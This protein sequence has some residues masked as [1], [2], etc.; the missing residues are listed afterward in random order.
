M[1]A[2]NPVTVS[3]EIP[4]LGMEQESIL[5]LIDF[6]SDPMPSDLGS[7][8]QNPIFVTETIEQARQQLQE[9][10]GAMGGSS[11]G[12]TDHTDHT[13]HTDHICSEQNEAFE[14]LKL[15]F[16]AKRNPTL[17]ERLQFQKAENE[18]L[19]R[20]NLVKRRK[21]EQH[22]LPASTASEPSSRLDLD[23]ALGP[24]I[25]SEQYQLFCSDDDKDTSNG[26]IGKP[27][28]TAE[29]E[30]SAL[31]SETKGKHANARNKI[32]RKAKRENAALGFDA[33]RRSKEKKVRLDILGLPHSRKRLYVENQSVRKRKQAGESKDKKWK[34]KVSGRNK[35]RQFGQL[36][37]ESLFSSDIINAAKANVSKPGIPTFYSKAKDKA[38][39][40]LIASIP[41]ADPKVVTT[42]KKAIM[43]AIVKFTRRPKA[44]GNG[45][46]LHPDMNTSLFH[47]QV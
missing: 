16:G 17:E 2:S 34:P 5:S 1:E 10:M 29:G 45:G 33:F 12:P 11:T 13:A 37:F 38:M 46:W 4:F 40:E 20:L 39:K 18:E 44:D 30:V 3:E 26:N 36:N 35:K 47:Y 9:R 15:E 7:N 23:S 14:K 43:A 22:E 8:A 19:Q 28:G 27:E 42:D 24:G 21:E 32:A 25:T 31:C 41:H 6:N